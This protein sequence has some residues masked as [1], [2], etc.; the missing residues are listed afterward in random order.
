MHLQLE[1]WVWSAFGSL[2]WWCH[3]PLWVFTDC[4][5]WLLLF[6]I[7]FNCAVRDCLRLQLTRCAGRRYSFY[8]T[9]PSTIKINFFVILESE[10]SGF[11]RAYYRS[12]NSVAEQWRLRFTADQLTNQLQPNL[13]KKFFAAARYVT[14]LNCSCLNCFQ[15]FVSNLCDFY[16]C[17][18]ERSLIIPLYCSAW[19]KLG[20]WFA[21]TIF[22]L[23]RSTLEMKL[24]ETPY[25]QLLTS[26]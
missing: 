19:I 5:A 14:S 9:F 26:V 13:L 25:W 8:D 4:F 7:N 15:S 20:R 11:H 21:I 23:Y 10:T 3:T 1:F 18:T 6:T 22:Q 24:N 17:I 12:I 16:Y 2:Q